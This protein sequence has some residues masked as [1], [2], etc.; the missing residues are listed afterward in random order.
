MKNVF[1]LILA[2]VAITSCASA[3][4]YRPRTGDILFQTLESDQSEAIQI[5]TK[6]PYSHVGVVFIRDEKPFV[7]EAVEPVQFTPMNIWIKR[8]ANRRYVAKRL[9]KADSILTSENLAELLSIG[10]S[11][12]GKHYDIYLAWSDSSMYCSELVWKL[13]HEA[14]DLDLTTPAKLSSFDLQHPVVSAKLK[15][16]YGTEVPLDEPVVAPAALFDSSY[17]TTVYQKK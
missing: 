6:S 10:K 13:Y 11:Y 1:Y 4:R 2:W 3:E 14:L 17:L 8:G 7:L 12:L 9:V 16:R 5:A 15:E